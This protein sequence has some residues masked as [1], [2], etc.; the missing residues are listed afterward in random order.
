MTIGFKRDLKVSFPAYFVTASTKEQKRN[1]AANN[2]LAFCKYMHAKKSTGAIMIDIDDTIM[3]RN[4]N[5][6]C[7]GFDVIHKF[8]NEASI[9]YPVYVVTARPRSEHAYVIRML[10]GKGFCLPP[11]RL[12]MLPTK[13]YDGP[14]RNVELFKWKKYLEIASRHDGVVLRMGDMLWDVACLESLH[15]YP[16]RP[17]SGWLSHIKDKDCYIFQDPL[18]KG[19]YSVKLPGR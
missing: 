11:D 10:R 4:Q 7:D 12:Y 2:A 6:E 15:A 9:L 14:H 17:R 18:M 3:N 8:Y 16:D 1:F 19:T 13:L 5:A